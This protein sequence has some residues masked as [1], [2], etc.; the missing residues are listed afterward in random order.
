MKRNQV[1]IIGS[2]VGIFGLIFLVIV[3]KKKKMEK[4][5]KVEQTLIYLPIRKALNIEAEQQIVSY[6]Q[7]ESNAEIDVVFE[8]QG[9]LESGTSLLKPGSMIS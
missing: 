1:V 8:V 3:L 9:K 5:T 4:P 6:G 7:I 2:L